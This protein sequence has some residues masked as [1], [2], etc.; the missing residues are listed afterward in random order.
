MATSRTKLTNPQIPQF[1]GKNYGYWAITMK[2]QFSSQ[3]IWD[4]V[5]NGFQEPGNSTNN[6][7]SQAKRDLLRDNRK[8]DAKPSST[9][10]KQFMKVFSQGLQQQRSP[11]KHGTPSR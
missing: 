1:N 3:D 7:L 4:L 9:S 11:I 2:A 6:A 5:E 10:F 8:M